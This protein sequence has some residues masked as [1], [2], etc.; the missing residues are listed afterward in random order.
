MFCLEPEDLAEGVQVSEQFTE[1]DSVIYES[2][3]LPFIN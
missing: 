1:M 2:A 3:D